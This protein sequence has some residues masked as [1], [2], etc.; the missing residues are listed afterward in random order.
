MGHDESE[1]WQRLFDCRPVLHGQLCGRAVH[2]EV[3]GR[4]SA[5]ADGKHNR[6]VQGC[7][8]F[9]RSLADPSGE[10]G[11]EP[12]GRVV[13]GVRGEDA[14]VRAEHPGIF[15]HDLTQDA[16]KFDGNDLDQVRSAIRDFS[17][18]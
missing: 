9:R 8:R 17:L 1:Q 13:G 16:E 7:R 5:R 2:H 18:K 10:V 11:G 3:R 4:P 12:L 6:A 15:R 14:T